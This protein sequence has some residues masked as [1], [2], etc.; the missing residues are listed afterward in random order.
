MTTPTPTA[1]FRET[2]KAKGVAEQ[3]KSAENA[4]RPYADLIAQKIPQ[5]SLEGDIHAMDLACGTGAMTAAFYDAIPT[6]KRDSARV[7]GADI[8]TDMLAY[9]EKRGEQE[10]WKGLETKAMDA[11]DMMLPANTYTHFFIT[12]GVFVMPN[13]TVQKCHDSIT[14]GGF[15]GISVWQ[16][17]P[18]YG[19]VVRALERLPSPPSYIPTEADIMSMV[20]AKRPWQDPEY[21]RKE[22]T[23]AGFENIEVVVEERDAE[24]GTA[25]DFAFTMGKPLE[26]VGMFWPE[27]GRAE[28]VEGV[29]K[30]LLAVAKEEIGEGGM[31]KMKFTGIV[32]TGLKKV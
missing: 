3:Y 12:F 2:W 28:L 6:A 31:M 19:M 8:S 13:G 5:S 16:K 14:P 17:L 24:T 27:E 11:G 18:W 29:K 20:C 9:L 23:D 21:L 1:D 4:T 7:V 32:G 22:L 10:G 15:V 30:E 26:M 25:E